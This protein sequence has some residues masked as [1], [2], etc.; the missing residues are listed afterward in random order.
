LLV[1]AL[2]LVWLVPRPRRVSTGSV[3]TQTVIIQTLGAG[4]QTDEPEDSGSEGTSPLVPIYTDSDTPLPK[5]P[6]SLPPREPQPRPSPQPRPAA[7]PESHRVTIDEVFAEI[8][9][10][11]EAY[12]VDHRGEARAV[13][14]AL[15]RLGARCCG[16]PPLDFSGTNHFC[17]RAKCPSCGAVALRYP[18][19]LP[20]R[21]YAG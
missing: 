21:V 9:R 19:R 2:L 1:G 11:C 7:Q 6:R 17:I 3:E 5:V 15:Q 4:T 14:F 10:R 8:S 18:S 16:R 13:S 12:P 20:R